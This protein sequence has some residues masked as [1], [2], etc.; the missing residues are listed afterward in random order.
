MVKKVVGYVVSVFG[1]LVMA[2][3]F[4]VIPIGWEILNIVPAGYVSGIGLV[5]VGAGVAIA[6]MSKE[7][8]VRNKRSGM[9]EIPIYEGVGRQRR[10]VGY[11]KA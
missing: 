2:V 5:L 8:G 11:R 4:N 9:D 6:L 7:S 10:V 1:I 3:G